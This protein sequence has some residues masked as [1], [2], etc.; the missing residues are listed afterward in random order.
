[1]R[2]ASLLLMPGVPLL[3][4]LSAASGCT[5]AANQPTRSAEN[6]TTV[7]VSAGDPRTGLIAFFDAVR[8]ENESAAYACWMNDVDNSDDRQYVEDLVHH[9]VTELIA[10][11]RFEQ[12][13]ARKLPRDYEQ[14]RRL[15][16]LIPNSIKLSS[17]RFAVYRR[18]AIV[19]WGDDEDD[20]YPMVLDNSG[21]GTPVWKLSMHQW[22]ETTRSSVGDSILI[23][24]WGARAKDLTTKELLAGK[25]PTLEAAEEAYLHHLLDNA[26]SDAKRES[27]STIPTTTPS[28][29]R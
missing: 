9:L 6:P 1:M 21:P 27:P 18:L 26:E 24:G 19:S 20:G 16:K 2:I 23:S 28:Q 29:S 25:F 14:Q 17:A 4:I 7:P 5:N 13:I 8:R 22:H 3:A 12:A 10:T 15:N 11:A